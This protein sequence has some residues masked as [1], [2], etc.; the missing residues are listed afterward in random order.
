[1]KNRALCL[2]LASF[3]AAPAAHAASTGVAAI[4]QLGKLNGLALACREQGVAT[5]AKELML[6]RAPR[7]AEYG[8][9]YEQATQDGF[10]AQ[11]KSQA[12][13]PAPDA[14]VQRFESIAKEVREKL[15]AQQ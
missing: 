9:A 14:L 8:T 15:P 13:C 5:R 2:L 1:M 10:M 7:T 3:L 6:A 11:V 12:D 4:E